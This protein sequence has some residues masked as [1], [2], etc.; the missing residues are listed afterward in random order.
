MKFP[1]H[2]AFW[3]RPQRLIFTDVAAAGAFLPAARLRRRP[4]TNATD[5]IL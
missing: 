3:T 4:A 1:I 2:F 5:E